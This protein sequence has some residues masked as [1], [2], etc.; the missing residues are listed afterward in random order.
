MKS[1][2]GYPTFIVP[3]SASIVWRRFRAFQGE[4]GAPCPAQR[5]AS[6]CGRSLPG[7]FL[8]SVIDRID[9]RGF[10]LTRLHPDGRP[11]L[12]GRRGRRIVDQH[13]DNSLLGI[14]PSMLQGALPFPILPLA[15]AIL[16]SN[17]DQKVRGFIQGALDF[18]EPTLSR[19]DAFEVRPGRNPFTRQGFRQPLGPRFCICRIRYEDVGHCFAH[20]FMVQDRPSHV[21]C[22][23]RPAN[24]TFSH[25]LLKRPPA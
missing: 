8:H 4:A 23:D 10:W 5:F 18:R 7:P 9:P 21:D 22:G 11:V 16:G 3:G 14:V 17:H 6:G 13:W 25:Q 1:T 2:I 20:A 24:G 19:P 12:Q 15:N